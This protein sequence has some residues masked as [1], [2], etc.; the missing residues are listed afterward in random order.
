MNLH[1]LNMIPVLFKTKSSVQK[2][3]RS[4]L[5]ATKRRQARACSS[6]AILHQ[7]VPVPEDTHVKTQTNGH[8]TNAPESWPTR[9]P[10]DWHK[11]GSSASLSE[12]RLSRSPCCKQ[13]RGLVRRARPGE[14]DGT[15]TQSPQ[16]VKIL[17]KALSHGAINSDWPTAKD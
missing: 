14:W 2:S 12:R 16:A 15:V 8:P 17:T 6:W 9:H 7:W 5:V 4:L 10:R 11:G 3:K 13:A 1:R